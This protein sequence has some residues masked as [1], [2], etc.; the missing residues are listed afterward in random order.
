MCPE[1][2]LNLGQRKMAVF[3]D[4]QATLLTTQPP[5]PRCHLHPFLGF[6]YQNTLEQSLKL[7]LTSFI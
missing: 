3:G 7:V 4:C 1:R 6:I 2:D 5:W